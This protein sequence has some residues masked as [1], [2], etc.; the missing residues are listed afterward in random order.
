[1][2]VIQ[3]AQHAAMMKGWPAQP[4][5]SGELRVEVLTQ[6]A[7]TQLVTISMARD[8]DGDAAA[9]IWS[10]AGDTRV[11][12]D[13]VAMLRHNMK[14][15]YGK[16]ALKDNDVV[17]VHALLDATADV[18]Q[19]AKAIFWVARAADDLEMGTYGAYSDTL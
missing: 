16:V 15:T 9:F 13:P 1:M 14:L 2:G 4:Q 7:R 8:G 6:A 19:V 11:I 12:A 17:V 10:K 3:Q 5:P 18:N